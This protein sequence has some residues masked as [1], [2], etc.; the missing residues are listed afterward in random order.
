MNTYTCPRCR[1]KLTTMSATGYFFC[2]PC[3]RVHPTW[4]H[5]EI[6]ARVMRVVSQEAVRKSQS[7]IGG[8]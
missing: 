1:T 5:K 7:A 3:C 8:Q 6:E 2:A 4:A